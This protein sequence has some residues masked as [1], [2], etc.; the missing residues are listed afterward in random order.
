MRYQGDRFIMVVS[1]HLDRNTTQAGH[2]FFD[3]RAISTVGF[4]NHPGSRSKEIASRRDRSATLSPCHRVGAHVSRGVLEMGCDLHR[5]LFLDTGNIDHHRLRE[6]AQ[7]LQ[8]HLGHNIGWRCD[9]NK[10][11]ITLGCLRR[12]P[13]LVSRTI[14][15][16]QGK[17]GR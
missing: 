13:A 9:N 16:G 4:A 2:K 11:R 1:A 10:L 3:Q 15:E 14:I 6:S 7:L 17:R 8:N 12:I 5:N